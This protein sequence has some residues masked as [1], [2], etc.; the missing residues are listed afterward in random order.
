MS[1]VI[2]KGWL[3]DEVKGKEGPAAKRCF[4]QILKVAPEPVSPHM[5]QLE[6]HYYC[7]LAR[8]TTAAASPKSGSKSPAVA[9]QFITLLLSD[10]LYFVKA[11]LTSTA[12]KDLIAYVLLPPMLRL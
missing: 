1:N 12:A 2:K 10:S 8:H 11:Y 7:K 5:Q 6:Q 9:E 3:L 4:V